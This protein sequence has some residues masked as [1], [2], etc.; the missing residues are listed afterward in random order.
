MK[1]IGY[2]I[3][4]FGYR[5]SLWD[6]YDGKYGFVTLQVSCENSKSQHEFYF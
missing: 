6:V 1:T 4:K 5:I 2:W 3:R